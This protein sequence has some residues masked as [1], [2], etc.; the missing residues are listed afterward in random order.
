MGEGQRPQRRHDV[1]ERKEEATGAL[2]TGAEENEV[3]SSSDWQIHHRAARQD[4]RVLQPYHRDEKVHAGQGLPR[5]R[6][7]KQRVWRQVPGHPRQKRDAALLPSLEK[8][9]LVGIYSEATC[10]ETEALN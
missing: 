9:P 2:A 3:E 4:Q 8:V 5:D 7:S 1:C 6:N 10:G